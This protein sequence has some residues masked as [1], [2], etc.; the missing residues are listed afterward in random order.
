MV[1]PRYIWG[2]V[3]N[4]FAICRAIKIFLKHLITGQKIG[5]DKTAHDFPEVSQLSGRKHRLGELLLEGN[6]LSREALDT[7][8]DE[9]QRTGQRLGKLLLARG[10]VKENQLMQ[11]LSSQFR[12][13][14][15]SIDASVLSP[16]VYGVLP[17]DTLREFR[18]MPLEK[19]QKGVL[20]VACETLPD[21]VLTTRLEHAADCRIE[22]C[23]A[24][25]SDISYGLHLLATV[26]PRQMPG[27]TPDDAPMGMC[28]RHTGLL[29]EPQLLEV[30]RKQREQYRPFGAYAVEQGY[31]NQQQLDESVTAAARAKVRLGTY[32]VKHGYISEGACVQILAAMSHNRQ[33]LSHILMETSTVLK[34]RLEE[35]KSREMVG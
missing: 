18:L 34:D 29:A 22:F 30:F 4:Y 17:F 3:I 19:R 27:D 33:Q 16:T 8:L 13:P 1:L 12:L 2:A 23:L 7:V 25:E 11:A 6:Y 14:V 21:A 35:G 15:Q 26:A 32:L 20:V 9:Q 28:S 24:T 5:W 31:L 10:L